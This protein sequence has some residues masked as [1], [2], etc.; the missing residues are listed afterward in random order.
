MKIIYDIF[1]PTLLVILLCLL[2]TKNIKK[3]AKY[4]YGLAIGISGITIAYEIF[5][6]VSGKKLTGLL[7]YSERMTMKGFFAI[8]FFL[9]VMFAGAINSKWRITKKLMSIRSEMAI[10]GAILIIPHVVIYI[11]QVILRLFDGKVITSMQWI[12]LIIGLLAVIIMIPLTITSF[13]SIKNK[14]K[15]IKW[16]SIQRWAYLFLLLIYIHIA[17]VLLSSKSFNWIKFTIYTFMF[18]LYVVLRINKANSKN[19]TL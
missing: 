7:Y 8:A 12:Y 15:Y 13:E 11:I 2:A 9:L 19:E 17:I 6:I 18:L 1:I 10:L 5:K 16:K 3:Y 4:Y 14:L